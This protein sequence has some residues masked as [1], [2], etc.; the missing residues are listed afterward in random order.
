M[1]YEMGGGLR[2]SLARRSILIFRAH[3]KIEKP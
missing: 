1:I 2:A 3:L